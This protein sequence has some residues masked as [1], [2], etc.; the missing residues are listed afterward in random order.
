MI[1]KLLCIEQCIRKY[2]IINSRLKLDIQKFYILCNFRCI[3]HQFKDCFYQAKVIA[4]VP[5]Q[6]FMTAV[7][8]SII[9]SELQCKHGCLFLCVSVCTQRA[10]DCLKNIINNIS[11]ISFSFITNRRIFTTLMNMKIAFKCYNN[12][13]KCRNQIIDS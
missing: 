3:I 8:A 4:F 13:I 5:F 10:I 9:I 6:T 1:R 2:D 11:K 12:D 7:I